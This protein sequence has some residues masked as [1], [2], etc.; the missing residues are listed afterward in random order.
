MLALF[1]TNQLLWSV[2]LLP[3]AFLLHAGIF[4]VSGSQPPAHAGVFSQWLYGII[5]YQGTLPDILAILLLVMQGIMMNAMNMRH[6]LGE[7]VNLFPGLF[8]I[9]VASLLPEFLHLSPLLLANTFYLIAFADLFSVYNQ[10]RSAGYLFNIGLWIGLASLFHFSYIILVFWSFFGLNILRAYD[11]R[12]RLMVLAG[13]LVPYLLTGLG[14][15]L[16]DAF[17]VFLESQIYQNIGF[18]DFREMPFS[19]TLTSELLLFAVPFLIV[20][21]SYGS[22]LSK[23][24]IQEQKKI[25]ILYWG[26]FFGGLTVCIQAGMGPE[27]ML[28]LAPSMGFLLSITF[29][30][31]KPNWAEFY[32]F[33]LLIAALFL[34]FKPLLN[35]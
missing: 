10:P 6:R 8:Y 17:P 20:L 4:A 11:I 28:I 29:V 21:F 19:W 33:V 26:L 25:N 35:L 22:F 16:N 13:V 3:Y 15:Y 27:Q 7:T 12:E 32:H 24:V 23:R 30:R 31:L 34:Q 9:L 2:L 14:Y 1:R 5:G 18:F